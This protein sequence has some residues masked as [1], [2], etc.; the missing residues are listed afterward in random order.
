MARASRMNEA[1]PFAANR[2]A[3]INCTQPTPPP[4]PGKKATKQGRPTLGGLAASLSAGGRLKRDLRDDRSKAPLY[5]L[6]TFVALPRRQIVRASSAAG[7]RLSTQTDR[8][9]SAAPTRA[10]ETWTAPDGSID[11]KT[12]ASTGHPGRPSLSCRV[13]KP[14]LRCRIYTKAPKSNGSNDRRH[15]TSRLSITPLPQR[16]DISGRAPLLKA[17]HQPR[18]PTMPR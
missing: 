16:C 14:V 2:L 13:T 3:S 17:R 1:K 6:Q 9:S 8:R 11:A 15:K 7:S 10:I 4:S 12:A 18:D 5:L